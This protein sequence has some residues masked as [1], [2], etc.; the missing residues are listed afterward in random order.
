MTQ[1]SNFR[2]LLFSNGRIQENFNIEQL[3]TYPKNQLYT[4]QPFLKDHEQIN[5]KQIKDNVDR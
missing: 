1:K 3:F 4:K 5:K 2:L